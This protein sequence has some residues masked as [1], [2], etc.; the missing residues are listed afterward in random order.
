VKT[1]DPNNPTLLLIGA[2]G[3]LGQAWQAVLKHAGVS[4]QGLTRAT[5]DLA[6]P[7]SI[8]AAVT[9]GV[10]TVINCAAWTDVDGAEDHE[11][12]ATA[13]NGQGVGCLAR[14]CAE[15]GAVLLHYSTD[16]VFN[17]QATEPYATDQ[18]RAPINAY[19]RSK[20]AG[21]QLIE[22]SGTP[23]LIVRTSWL[24]APWG[25]NFVSTMRRLMQEQERLTVV[26][27][28]RGR[29]TSCQHLAEVSW[30]LLNQAARG[31][32]HATDGGQ[33]TWFDLACQIREALDAD[34]TIEPCTSEAF[35]RPA[36]RP[37]YSVLDLSATE[38]ALGPMPHWS[39]NVEAALKQMEA[40]V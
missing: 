20:A 30:Q 2:D 11:A 33:C 4:Y 18:S 23:H 38:R 16:Y 17:G 8:E 32:Y 34:C 24:Y 19:G 10:R 1:A 35:P 9:P 6:E 27:D 28:Q 7:T 3:M 5:L 14:R 26:N 37:A 29:P 21:E 40:P 31:I 25:K 12:Q 36:K 39:D 15:I 13:V 22:Q